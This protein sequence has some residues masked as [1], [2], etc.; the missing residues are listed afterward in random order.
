MTERA[1][2]MLLKK[3]SCAASNFITL[4]PSCLIHQMLTSNTTPADPS[5]IQCMAFA[6]E[7][8]LRAGIFFLP[9]PSPIL[10]HQPLPWNHFLTRPN[11]PSV[12]RYVQIVR[13][14]KYVRFAGNLEA[15]IFVIIKYTSIY[16]K[17]KMMI[18]CT[19]K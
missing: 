12:L 11:F 14:A 10:T 8:W 7:L 13:P 18:K 16:K 5:S 2:K 15:I 17:R 19:I 9:S 6:N 1:T 4:I 3:W